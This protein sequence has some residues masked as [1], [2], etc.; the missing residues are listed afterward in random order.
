MPERLDEPTG[1]GVPVAAVL[2][3][4]EGAHGAFPGSSL[5][6]VQVR[7]D[8]AHAALK[9]DG[10]FPH[11]VRDCL[12]RG[13]GLD[14]IQHSQ[15]KSKE[16]APYVRLPAQT[17]GGAQ[18]AAGTLRIAEGTGHVGSN[19]RLDLPEASRAL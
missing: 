14:A 2:V 12:A 19:D 11:G 16:G 13:G 15:V 3:G 8:L 7:W 18:P 9:R 10:A 17:G 5:A 1:G 6:E 4:V